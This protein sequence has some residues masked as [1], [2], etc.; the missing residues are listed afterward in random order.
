MVRGSGAPVGTPSRAGLRYLDT[1]TGL[2]YLSRNVLNFNNSYIATPAITGVRKV[3][4]QFW[5]NDPAPSATRSMFS[6]LNGDAIENFILAYRN[7]TTG[8]ITNVGVVGIT[9]ELNGVAIANN[10]VNPTANFWSSLKVSADTDRKLS[11][12][13]SNAGSTNTW[14]GKIA[15]VQILG[16]GDVLLAQ[17]AIDEGSGTTIIDSS[18]NGQNGTLTLGSGVW[19]LDWV[20]L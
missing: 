12:I 1:T 15:N 11:R 19:Q 5:H 20:P 9:F 10:A 7:S 6:G 2:L 16:A 17:Y 18:G 8:Y 3:N 4:L 14:L 13:G